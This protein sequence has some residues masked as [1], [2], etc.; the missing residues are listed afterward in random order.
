MSDFDIPLLSFQELVEILSN[1]DN[2]NIE[3][4][5][6]VAGWD[7]G[8]TDAISRIYGINP[9]KDDKISDRLAI[10]LE[11]LH[12]KPTITALSAATLKYIDLIPREE[13]GGNVNILHYIVAGDGI[14]KD[15]LNII[16]I[17]KF[18]NKTKIFLIFVLFIFIF[19]FSFLIREERNLYNVD[20]ILIGSLI[21]TFVAYKLYMFFWKLLVKSDPS[22]LETK[23]RLARR[24]GIQR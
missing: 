21:E 15:K 2:N 16:F 12:K 1:E 3:K 4:G 13:I 10:L 8:F 9:Q 23:I 18:G 22:N 24:M 19:I 5:F 7:A 14:I 11:Y 17:R 20:N 6:L